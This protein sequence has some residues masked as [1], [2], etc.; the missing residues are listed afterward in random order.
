MQGKPIYRRW[1]HSLPR[2]DVW[3]A[4]AATESLGYRLAG[5]ISGPSWW[6]G[7]RLAALVVIAFT[8]PAQKCNRARVIGSCQPAV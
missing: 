3:A 7:R 5:G 6:L 8:A 2:T 1:T 4:F